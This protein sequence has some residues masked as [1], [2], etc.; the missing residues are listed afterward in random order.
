MS[1]TFNALTLALAALHDTGMP[2]NSLQ[3]DAIAALK[4]AIQYEKNAPKTVA[5]QSV[6]DLL[7]QHH[8]LAEGRH[9]Y[10]NTCANIVQITFGK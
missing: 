5:I 7:E 6:I 3:L 8:K 2:K 4:E 9:N 10:F 1:P